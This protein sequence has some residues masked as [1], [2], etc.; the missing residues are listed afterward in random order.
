MA[1]KPGHG[2]S[3]ALTKSFKSSVKKQKAKIASGKAIASRSKEAQLQAG[4]DYVKNQLG[5]TTV[6][7]T[8]PPGTKWSKNDS[9][10]SIFAA[11]LSGKDKWMYGEE[12]SRLTNQYLADIGLAKK[13]SQ[14]PD[15][16]W[17][18]NL[19]SEGWEMKYGSYT[20]GGTQ[21]PGAMGSGDPRGI[22]TSTPI[23]KNMLQSQNKLKGAILGIAG[24]A[25]GGN[26]AGLIMRGV[27]AKSL[28]DAYATPGKA[29][30]TYTKKF[31][32]RQQGK[33]FTQQRN[34]LG[35]LGLQNEKKT[36]KDT[37]G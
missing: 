14:N 13:S 30:D 29:Y 37:L 8:P 4:K 2:R 15:G 16:S 7:N 22:I 26:P 12:T 35:V 10:T 9:A 34:L 11:N 31:K 27:G 33:K 21:T 24:I 19:T 5:L 20:P 6:P 23:S 25:A 18:Y 36:K 3:G 17:N 32:A 1:H 28:A